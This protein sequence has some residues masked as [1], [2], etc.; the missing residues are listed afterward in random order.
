MGAGLRSHHRLVPGRPGAPVSWAQVWAQVQPAAEKIQVRVVNGTSRDALQYYDHRRDGLSVIAVGGN[1][2]SRGLT[3]EGL[4]VSY[5]LRAIQDVRHAAA[6]GPL[7]RLPARTTRTCAACTLPPALRDAYAEITAAN[8]ELR[9]EF[10]E[11]AALDAKPEE[12]GLRVRTSPAGLEITARNKMRRGTEGQAQLLRRP[13]RDR[14]LR[15][16]RR[17]RRRELPIARRFVGRLDAARQSPARRRQRGLD[18]NIPPRTSST[19]SW[20]TTSASNAHRVR[21]KFIADYIR[22]CQRVGELGNWTVRLVSSK[23]GDAA[24]RSARTRSA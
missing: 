6:D 10:E 23:T 5:Y 19:G 13:A 9:R 22:N 15:H 24:R 12:F 1:K 18:G 8:D 20:P 4:S 16:A 2:L 11:M 17:S 21:P 14:R 3:L 7:V